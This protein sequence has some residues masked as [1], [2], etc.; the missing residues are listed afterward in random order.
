[1]DN[2]TLLSINNI[3]VVYSQVI[4]ALK[5]V[6][7]DVPEGKIVSL[8]GSNGAGKTTTLKACSNLLQAERGMVTKGM[9]TFD[10]RD[11]TELLP[12]ELVER[13]VVQVLEGRHCF[14]TSAL[15]KTC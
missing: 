7:L 1:M 14:P 9:I 4:L 3:E 15:K 6:T 13:G 10:G 8:L 11:I 12:H 2:N 5:G